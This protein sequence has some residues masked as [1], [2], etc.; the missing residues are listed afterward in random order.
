MFF[1]S[2]LLSAQT[3]T[4]PEK[5]PKLSVYDKFFST[6]YDL[7][8]QTKTYN[9]V[10]L[11]L[12]QHDEKAHWDFEMASRN[13]VTSLVWTILGTAAVGVYA[14]ADDSD[15]RILSIGAASVSFSIAL[16]YSLSS[17]NKISRGVKRYNTKYGY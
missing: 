11:H 7:G 15:V 14:L 2:A 9:E 8:G 12:K 3:T 16:G 5:P 13:S 1:W 10:K 17:K 4:T 6:E